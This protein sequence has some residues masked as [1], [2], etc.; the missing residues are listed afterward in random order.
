MPG[1]REAADIQPGAPLGVSDALDRCQRGRLIGGD[2]ASEQIA[3]ADLQG[4]DDRRRRQ[5]DRDRLAVIG[6]PPAAEH[7]H[8]Y[9]LATPNV[10]AR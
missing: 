10:V 1:D 8:A 9:T 7:A 5:G 6:V 4:S 2:R 3:D